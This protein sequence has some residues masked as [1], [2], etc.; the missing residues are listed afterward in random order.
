M[1]KNPAFHIF[2]S[3]ETAFFLSSSLSSSPSFLFSLPSPIASFKLLTLFSLKE[4]RH[5]VAAYGVSPALFLPLSFREL[6]LRTSIVIVLLKTSMC[7][8]QE[9]RKLSLAFDELLKIVPYFRHIYTFEKN[10][11]DEVPLKF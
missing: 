10:V 9:K 5:I 3:T 7:R 11:Y 8:K 4:A 1:A 2:S 6:L